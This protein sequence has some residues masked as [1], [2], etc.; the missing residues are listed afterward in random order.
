[1]ALISSWFCCNFYTFVCVVLG[2]ANAVFLIE[3]QTPADCVKLS[4]GAPIHFYFNT[5]QLKCM[6]CQQPNSAQTVSADGAFGRD[7]ILAHYV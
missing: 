5:V 1:M 4:A 7:L 3:Y 2:I 6:E